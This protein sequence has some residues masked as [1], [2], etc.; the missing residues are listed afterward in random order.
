[1]ATI[2]KD[3]LEPNKVYAVQFIGENSQKQRG[4]IMTDVK[5]KVWRSW[6]IAESAQWIESELQLTSKHRIYPCTEVERQ[7]AY[8]TLNAQ[9]QRSHNQ[10]L[11]DTLKAQRAELQ[12]YRH[13]P[14]HQMVERIRTFFS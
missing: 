14:W 6:N 13:N 9:A 11:L 3:N 10:K 4:I 5:R 8:N 12:K 1:M 2:N 7:F